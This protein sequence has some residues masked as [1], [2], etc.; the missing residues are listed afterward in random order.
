[1]SKQEFIRQMHE[2]LR[3]AFRTQWSGDGES[4]RLAKEVLERMYGE[5]GAERTARAVQRHIEHDKF[6]NVSE[7]RGQI[8]YSVEDDKR[9]LKPNYLKCQQGCSE[10]WQYT[11]DPKGNSC[12]RPCSCRTVARGVSETQ[13]KPTDRSGKMHSVSETI[14]TKPED[15]RRLFGK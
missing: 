9:R 7:L 5:F 12:V 15:V 2:R 4:D 3:A 8:S 10:G 11:K 13:G 14:G 6:F 1:M